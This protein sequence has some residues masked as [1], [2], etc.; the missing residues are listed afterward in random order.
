MNANFGLL[1]DLPSVVKDKKRKRELFA[2]RSLN[3]M[4]AWL[5]VHGVT[6]R[7]VAAVG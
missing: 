2:E 1:E 5:S 7:P 3:E 6:E 4:K